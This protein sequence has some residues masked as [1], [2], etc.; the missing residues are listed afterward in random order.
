[1]TYYRRGSV[2]SVSV[3]LPICL[4]LTSCTTIKAPFDSTPITIAPPAPTS[5]LSFAYVSNAFGNSISMYSVSSSGTWTST[6]PDTVPAG[7]D[8]ES[9]VVDPSGRYV[10][11]PSARANTVSMLAI[12]LSNG[13][14]TPMSPATVPTGA[15]PQYI[16][17]DPKG[18]FV[19][20]ANTNDNSVSM[21]TIDSAGLLH[22]TSPTSVSA[23]TFPGS[24]PGGVTVDPTGRFVYTSNYEGSLSMFS[25]DQ[26]SGV[27]TPIGSGQI[28][29]CNFP[30]TLAIE[31]TGHFAYVPDNVLNRVLIFVIDQT[32][33][34][35][36]P[37]SQKYIAVDQG[38]TS[39]GVDPQ[40]RFL[41]VVNRNAQTI[42]QFDID[43]ADGSLAPMSVPTISDSGQ[44]WQILIDPSGQL[45]YVSNEQTN[46]VD[47][48][49]IG[50]DGSLTL[51]SSAPTGSVPG[52]MG[53]A[54]KR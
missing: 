7:D 9:L 20:T 11:V 5:K 47:I 44:P 10:Y 18:R 35:L 46:M 22:V 51:Y 16:A 38:P 21:F 26:T 50:T 54:V 48:Y 12:N 49:S 2:F 8:I 31:P 14:L 4:C 23:G 40:S 28:T 3:V 19:Y 41:Y 34:A 37:A 30:F 45:A 17:A 43:L 32:S 1:M 13:L 29:C 39:V 36:T 53:I 6:S 25:I 52:G 33:G 42:A 15:F 24:G 27:L